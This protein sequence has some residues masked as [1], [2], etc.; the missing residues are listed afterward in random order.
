MVAAAKMN[1]GKMACP[2]CGEPVAVM[3]A[4]ATGTLSLKCQEADC[5]AS[6]F[7]QAHTAAARKWLAKLPA[8]RADAE[9]AKAPPP[10]PAKAPAPAPAKA[11]AK[12]PAPA[13]A[14]A[15]KPARS[16]FSLGAL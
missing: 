6:L 5:E 4:P 9:P 12:A 8:P 13:P 15:P 7:A 3:K 14:P 2:C 16:P 11:P 10:A 1:L